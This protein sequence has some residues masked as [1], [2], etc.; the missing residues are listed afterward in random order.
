LPDSDKV[1]ALPAAGVVRPPFTEP[2]AR[3]TSDPRPVPASSEVVSRSQTRDEL[4][5]ANPFAA[6]RRVP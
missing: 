5:P 3:G 4:V 2:Q 1:G 6:A